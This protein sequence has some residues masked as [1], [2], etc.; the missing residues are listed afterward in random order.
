MNSIPNF[1]TIKRE[2]IPRGFS[3]PLKT[4]ELIAAYDSA[5]INTETILN[6]S[7]NHPNFRVHFWPPNVNIN[8]ERLYIVI[9]AVP[10]ESAYA[11]GE[12][13]K[14]KT[15]PEFIKWIKN[16]L[17]LPVNSPMRNQ[18]QLWEFEISHII[19]NS[20]ESI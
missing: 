14:S 19:S 4:S 18:S 10:T 15:V 20:K 1:L 16:L 9:G 5:E 3:Y 11:A 12:I 8:H 17:L 6:Y 2:K 7:F 13:I